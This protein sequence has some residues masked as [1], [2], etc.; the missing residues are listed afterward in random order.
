MCNYFGTAAVD[1]ERQIAA[2]AEH[3]PGPAFTEIEV[4]LEDLNTIDD[5]LPPVYY[6]IIGRGPMA[7]V[8]HRTLVQSAWGRARIGGRTVMHIGFP[9]P[10][11]QYFEHGLGQPTHLLSLPGFQNQP[12]GIDPQAFNGELVVDGGLNS[13]AFGRCIDDEFA[14]LQGVE[15]AEEWVALIQSRAEPG[16]LDARIG[17]E[18]GG[19][20]VDEVLA[21]RLRDP[22]PDF[23]DEHEAHYRL[24]LYDPVHESARWV[25]AAFIDICTGPGR[26][27]VYRPEQGDSDET[28][29]ARTPPWLTPERWGQVDRWRN[30]RTLNGVDAIRDEIQFAPD[31]R[32][33]VTAGGGVGL[34][35]AEKS[36]ENRCVLD[37][38]G[39]ESLWP[40]FENH[41]NVT[42]LQDRQTQRRYARGMSLLEAGIRVADEPDDENNLLPGTT[43]HRMG[44]G[45][46][47]NTVTVVEDVLDVGLFHYVP[48][49]GGPIPCVI[50]DWWNQHSGLNTGGFWE[51]SE[52][53]RR[54]LQPLGLQPSTRYDRL[55]IPNGQGTRHVGQPHAFADHLQFQPE[56]RLG[57][58]VALRTGDGR[59]R[60]LGAACN[61]YPTYD[62]QA[63]GRAGEPNAS[64]SDHMWHYHR[65]LPVC[66]VPD[67]FIICG[68]NTAEANRYFAARPNTNVNTMTYEQ[69][70]GTLGNEELATLIYE[71]RHARNGYGSREDLAAAC[72]RD[73]PAF[74]NL[75][76]AYGD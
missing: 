53:Y 12:S 2:E 18:E 27:N 5:R 17:R 29:G 4:S 71:N 76:F 15:V 13:Q 45:A 32:I 55:V 25:Y 52:D 10:W 69:I 8:D 43:R 19:G 47:L 9:N 75:R 70:R 65:Y 42:Y 67:G 51:F 50:R 22:W 66:A 48:D 73:D 44:N 38:F 14:L 49:G 26:P 35:A 54:E 6:V 74:A 1:E 39:R 40:I 11:P 59:V 23:D 63:W 68:V 58:M 64:A 7:V 72:G 61:D 31:Q 3:E 34:N 41:R 28:R 37:W 60:I 30:R 16:Q 57:R 21:P 36:R 24:C 62:V 33:C 20:R 56:V 46:S